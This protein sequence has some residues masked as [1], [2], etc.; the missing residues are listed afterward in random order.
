VAVAIQNALTF[1]FV[2]SPLG[3]GTG[4]S[5]AVT[6]WK[7]NPAL[8]AEVTLRLVK[9]LQDAT[10]ANWNIPSK[11]TSEAKANLSAFISWHG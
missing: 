7:L 1:A 5:R 10:S 3:K 2:E 11:R 4:F 6:K 9:S 8:A